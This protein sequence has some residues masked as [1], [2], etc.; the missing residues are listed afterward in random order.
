[1][2]KEKKEQIEETK[3]VS[4]NLTNKVRKAFEAMSTAVKGVVTKAIVL[5][6]ALT[7]VKNAAPHGTF[8]NWCDDNIP[9][10]DRR[11]IQMYMQV[12]RN[13]VAIESRMNSEERTYL[14]IDEAV[15]IAR[16][17][18]KVEKDKARSAREAEQATLN[19]LFEEYRV[20]KD[21][22]E[23]INDRLIKEGKPAT[24]LAQL[25]EG[26]QEVKQ[27]TKKYERWLDK[28]NAPEPEPTGPKPWSEKKFDAA[29]DRIRAIIDNVPVPEQRAQLAEFVLDKLAEYNLVPAVGA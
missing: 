19:G 13:R 3:E 28:M 22:A 6:E 9:E 7:E 4:V 5:G 26:A 2:A 21:E 15:Q 8:G 29:V 23:A 1:M 14:P 12:A 11:T 20:A 25:P 16:E 17:A 27:F 10:L 24:V 18:E